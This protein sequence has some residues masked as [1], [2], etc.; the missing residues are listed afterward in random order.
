MRGKW[1]SILIS[2]LYDS[3]SMV[4]VWYNG[5]DP[6]EGKWNWNEQTRTE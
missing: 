1:L 5:E 3:D 6:A 2:L 4:F